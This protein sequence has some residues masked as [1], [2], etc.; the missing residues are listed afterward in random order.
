MKRPQIAFRV[1]AS[2]Q[3]G[4]GHVM[5]CLTLANAL[6]V[7]GATCRF[8]CRS[9]VGE[10]IDLL[11][12]HDHEVLILNTPTNNSGNTASASPYADW[13]LTSWQ[14][15]AQQTQEA[16]APA[17]CQDWLIVDHYALDVQWERA[18]SGA[19]QRLLVIDDLA[20]RR[21]CANL[22][23]DQTFE[24]KRE[25]YLSLVNA[26]CELYCGVKYLMLRPEF[27]TWRSHSL[28][29][30]NQNQLKRILVSLGGVDQAN[31][32]RDILLAL[33]DPRISAD[34]DICVVL[35]ASSPW[36]GEMRLLSEKM[37]GIELI[38][39]AENMAELLSNCDMV[40]GAAGASAWERCCLGVPT[41]MLVLADNQREI[42]W[43]LSAVGAALILTPGPGLHEQVVNT[44]LTIQ[45]NPTQLGEMSRKASAIVPGS[46]VDRI[47][48]AM[49]GVLEFH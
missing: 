20:N 38:V 41:V 1:D 11:R 28:A 45:A 27:D 15:D 36:I 43:R 33:R 44:I 37:P 30:R 24:R 5:R 49:I 17:G 10:L 48:Q 29:K 21:H 19:Y 42:A 39:A 2:L 26:E 34:L 25:D 3:I 4:A 9:Q 32:S 22:L 13:L 18:V 16:L 46:G 14:L 12:K 23:L 31:V 35:G 8:V 47:V 6:R 7:Q 40:I